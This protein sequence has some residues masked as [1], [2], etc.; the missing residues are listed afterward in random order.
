VFSRLKNG[1]RPPLEKVEI[2]IPRLSLKLR[3]C[4]TCYEAPQAIISMHRWPSERH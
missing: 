2:R 1:V 3:L 4:M